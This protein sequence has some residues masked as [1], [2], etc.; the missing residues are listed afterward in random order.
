LFVAA[1]EAPIAGTESD[2]SSWSLSTWAIW[3]HA[4]LPADDCS[5][6][7]YESIHVYQL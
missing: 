5:R 2:S 4:C 1:E 7:Q 3:E 6:G